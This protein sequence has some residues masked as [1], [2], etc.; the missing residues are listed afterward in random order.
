MGGRVSAWIPRRGREEERSLYW[1]ARLHLHA[2]CRE[3]CARAQKQ[4]KFAQIIDT[5]APPVETKHRGEHELP[6]RL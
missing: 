3:T 6:S 4:S 5:Q 1:R 2:V